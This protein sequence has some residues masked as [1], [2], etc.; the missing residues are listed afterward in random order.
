MYFA[1]FYC[2]SKL[3]DL[4]YISFELLLVGLKL[5]QSKEMSKMTFLVA[6]FNRFQ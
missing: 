1:T 3:F 2:Y 4:S 6:F 5:D